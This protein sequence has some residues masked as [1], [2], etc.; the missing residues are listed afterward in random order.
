MKCDIKGKVVVITGGAGR[1]GKEF[2]KAVEEN[3]GIAVVA[4]LKDDVDITS[5]QSLNRL[6]S[7]VKAKYGR[8]D[9]LVNSAYP[10]NKNYGRKFENV[11][12]E[13][14]CENI[15]LHLGGY[16]LAAQQFALFFKKQGDGNIINVASIY[17]VVAP[18]FELYQG[19][20]MTMPVEYAAI[21]SAVIHLTKYLASYFKGW[22]VRV[23]AI[24]PGGILA[25]Q[26]AGFL[27]KYKEACLTK[28]MLEPKDVSGALLFL[29]SDL[30]QYVSGQNLVV[31]DG[32][33]L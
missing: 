28:G 31:D 21:K 6:I 3:G 33:C 13:D 26:P 1:L 27:K 12:Y 23:N 9:A 16:F 22:N 15:S 17:G 29:I 32:Y 24:S 25:D 4:D 30:S 19:T 10:R 18:K 2:V 11:T 20:K 5:K 8:I 14:F 7:K